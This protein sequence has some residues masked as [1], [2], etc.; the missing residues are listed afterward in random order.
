MENGFIG[1]LCLSG[2][3]P[4]VPLNGVWF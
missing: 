3:C 2:P 1:D 4:L